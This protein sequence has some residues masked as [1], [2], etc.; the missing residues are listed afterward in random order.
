MLLGNMCSQQSTGGAL[1]GAR[2]STSPG[3]GGYAASFRPQRLPGATKGLALGVPGDCHFKLQASR[4]V[5]TLHT[6]MEVQKKG[7]LVME[8][9][10]IQ[11]TYYGQRG[12][13]SRH[14]PQGLM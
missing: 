11:E 12:L 2:L 9:V 7:R 6:K 3:E 4:P 14:G 1:D 8:D 13:N 10:E 5:T